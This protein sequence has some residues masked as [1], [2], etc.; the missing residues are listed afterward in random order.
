M[1]WMDGVPLQ[2]FFRSMGGAFKEVWASALPVVGDAFDR[3]HNIV[4]TAA[5][6]TK[7]RARKGEVGINGQPVI[8][9]VIVIEFPASTATAATRILGLALIADINN[10]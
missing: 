8:G 2:N 1:G 10:L 6:I 5:S 3:A 9:L 7:A 4:A